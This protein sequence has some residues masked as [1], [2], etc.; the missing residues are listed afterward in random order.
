[1]STCVKIIRNNSA[2]RKPARTAAYSML[3]IFLL[4]Y[5]CTLQCA[6][7]NSAGTGNWSSR[8]SWSQVAGTGTIS[9]TDGSTAVTGTG[10]AFTSELSVGDILITDNGSAI[11]IAVASI[12]DDTHLTLVS[13]PSKSAGL[14][15]FMVSRLPAATDDVH[16]IGGYT[17]T[18]DIS[19]AYCSS[20]SIGNGGNKDCTL[21]FNANSQLSVSSSV[22]LNTTNNKT[23]LLDMTNGGTLICASL[24]VPSTGGIQKFT[25]G[26]GTIILTAGNTIPAAVFTT[27]NNLTLQA[28][29]TTTANNITINGTLT[30]AGTASLSASA[31]PIIFGTNGTLRYKGSSLQTA[32]S[33]E[34]PAASSPKNLIIDNPSGVS[35]G[36]QRTL[37]G[38]MTVTSGS[39]CTITTS[40]QLTVSGTLTNNAGNSGIIIE[41]TAA[42][43]GSLIQNTS[44]VPMTIQR[45][46]S[47]FDYISG[48]LSNKKYHCV[49]VPLVP[50]NNSVSGLFMGSYLYDWNP[51]TNA[52]VAWSAP[53]TTSMDETEGFMI[54]YPHSS[55]TTYNFAGEANNG[56]FT[57]NT[58]ATTTDN[59]GYYL[60][61]NPYPSAID[62]NAGT[63]WTKT[64]IQN[65]VSI[66]NSTSQNYATYINGVDVN[67][68]SRYIQVG[69]SFFVQSNAASPV[70]SMNN[71]VRVHSTTPF[72]KEQTSV[73]D[74]LRLH[75]DANGA[76]DELV[77]Y[78]D[79]AG[80]GAQKIIGF[81]GPPKIYSYSGTQ[82]MAIQA[83]PH[84]SQPTSVEVGFQMTVDSLVTLTASEFES[85]DPF[86][87][88]VLEDNLSGQL[89]DLRTNPVYTFAHSH[90]NFQNRFT[91]HFGNST[92]SINEAAHD[93]SIYNS[94]DKIAISIPSLVGKEA[95]IEILDL[96]GRLLWTSEMTLEHCSLIPQPDVQGIVLVRVTGSTGIFTSRLMIQK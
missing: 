17:I 11:S 26:S 40:G 57:C 22:T 50:S 52:F 53:T 5:S 41:S 10:T 65:S 13:T 21:A 43:T 82:M 25:A 95:M 32:T 38:N 79:D 45:F 18:V 96:T 94:N 88:I 86:L 14:R 27:F 59:I 6:V 89:I 4:V 23:I 61:P 46:V 54:F 56:T 70:L 77:I 28:G 66:W 44:N 51:T 15:N 12:I 71:D 20:I 74:I 9:Y 63:G 47:G 39:V 60:V 42:G 24:A 3:Y 8:S 49:S 37:S 2:V 19:N 33:N 58:A 78:F 81:N 67:G 30:M 92:T 55:G 76:S 36:L 80:E 48:T 1:M 87:S 16:I 29:T 91:V 7:I 73:S 93:F 75:V 62:W 68:G 34:F 72:L 83:L 90:S 84:Y 85:F 31:Y 64:N 69:Q 35:F